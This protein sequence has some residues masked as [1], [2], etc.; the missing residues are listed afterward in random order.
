VGLLGERPYRRPPWALELALG[1]PWALRLGL[2]PPWALGLV[3]PWAL[4]REL[5]PPSALGPLMKQQPPSSPGR[6]QQEDSLAPETKTTSSSEPVLPPVAWVLRT[7][8]KTNF[9][10]RLPPHTSH[11]S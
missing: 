8:C 2:G 11:T 7:S 4:A 5:V 9:L 3:P 1:P 10:L 6:E